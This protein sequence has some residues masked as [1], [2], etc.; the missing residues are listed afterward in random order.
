M[1]GGFDEGFVNGGEDGDLGLRAL[2]T[3]L[4]IGWVDIPVTHYHSQSVGRLKFSKENQARLDEK[5]NQ[6]TMNFLYTGGKKKI[7]IGTNHL[8][9]L[10]GSET[11]TYTLAKELEKYHDVDVFTMTDECVFDDLNVVKKPKKKYDYIIVSHNTT[12]RELSDVNGRKIFISH[13]VYPKIEQPMEGADKYIAISE[14]VKENM[15]EKG[16]ECEVVHNGIDCNRFYPQKP[17]R[18]KLKKVLSMCQGQEA[19][20]MV[21]KACEEMGIE[22]EAIERNVH[23]VEDYINDADLVVSLG[24]G[25]ME[26][27]SCGREVFIFDKRAYIDEP[28]FGDG[29]VNYNNWQELIKH[30]FSGR[31]RKIQYIV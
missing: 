21:K 24:R 2:S 1:L 31:A 9:R 10:G 19:S 3:G 26:A 14:E 13:G 8:D 22:F 27:M 6:D 18:N 29:L 4:K 15:K 12:L 23:N 11:F 28:P 5:W 7:L 30:N 20:N 16:Y 17:I 25:V